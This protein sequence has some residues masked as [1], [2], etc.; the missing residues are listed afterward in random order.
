[1]WFKEVPQVAN[2]LEKRCLLARALLCCDASIED[3]APH[4]AGGLDSAYIAIQGDYDKEMKELKEETLRNL[5]NTIGYLFFCLSVRSH[6][7]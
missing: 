5:L 7:L 4:K 6:C 2:S 3:P 1:M